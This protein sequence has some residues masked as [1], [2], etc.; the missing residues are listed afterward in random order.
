ML[1]HPHRFLYFP[2][3]LMR[4]THEEAAEIHIPSRVGCRLEFAAFYQRS[5]CQDVFG[6]IACP[7]PARLFW[8]YLLRRYSRILWLQYP[9]RQLKGMALQPYVPPAVQ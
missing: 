5:G 4:N 8:R 9:H 7:S 1:V 2:L 3:H 6:P